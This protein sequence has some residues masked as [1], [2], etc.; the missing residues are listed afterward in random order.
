MTCYV[1]SDDWG[2]IALVPVEKQTEIE[3]AL[4]PSATGELDDSH[5]MFSILDRQIPLDELQQLFDGL[6]VEA[7][8]LLTGYTTDLEAVERGFAFFDQDFGAFYGTLRDGRVDTLY[9]DN[10]A[11]NCGEDFSAAIAAFARFARH[12]RLLLVD[13]YLDLTLIFDDETAFERYLEEE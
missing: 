1:H 9:F 12:H 5:P 3:Q 10:Q 6:L 2:M 4:E 8:Q 11:C 13:W 7:D